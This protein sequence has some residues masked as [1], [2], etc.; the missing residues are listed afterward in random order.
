VFGIVPNRNKK[1]FY[2]LGEGTMSTETEQEKID[3][4]T[5]VKEHNGKNYV[6]DK[7][8]SAKQVVG[9][10]PTIKLADLDEMLGEIEPEQVFKLA[11][12]QLRTDHKNLVR[13]KYGSTKAS[14]VRVVAAIAAETITTEQIQEAMA[15]HSEDFTT[16]A[17]RLL[18][19]EI[20]PE[21]IHW[22]VLK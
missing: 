15:R 10:A 14:A 11:Y 18:T 1:L 4:N 22:D 8:T 2:N 21:R 16:A 9:F 17:T 13:A 19:T 20:D 12:R 7:V 5:E 6:L 3:K